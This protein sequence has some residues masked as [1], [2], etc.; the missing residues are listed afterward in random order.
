[1]IDNLSKYTCQDTLFHVMHLSTDHLCRVGLSFD[2][3]DGAKGF[4]RHI[5]ALTSDPLNIA[6]SGP[7]V[8]K[9]RYVCVCARE[10]IP[11]RSATDARNLS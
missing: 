6:L 5:Q 3:E 7:G 4:H 1:M 2:A 10:G 8:Y 9:S 11:S